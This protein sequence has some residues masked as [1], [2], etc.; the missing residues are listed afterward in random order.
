MKKIAISMI[1][2][3]LIC[4][5][6]LSGC[7]EKKATESPPDNTNNNLLTENHKPIASISAKPPSGVLPVT[8]QFNGTGTD[9]DGTITSYHWDFDDGSFSTE[10]NPTHTFTSE[11]KYNI[12]LDVTDD[13]N[14]TGTVTIQI[15]VTPQPPVQ[16]PPKEKTP[17][18]SY[19]TLTGNIHNDY[20]ITVDVDYIILSSGDWHDL[21]G[22]IYGIN[23]NGE[24][25]FSS[26]VKAGYGKYTLIVGWFHPYTDIQ[27][28]R[29]DYVFTNPLARDMTFDITILSNGDINVDEI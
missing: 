3:V 8:Y 7:N 2:L 18:R 6:L 25:S 29:V 23:Q 13:D 22:T 21:G 5:G 28:D 16:E 11:G 24:N 20:D 15:I 26:N 4:I 10:Q 19:F 1:V 27:A 17:E 14:A 9:T 12:V